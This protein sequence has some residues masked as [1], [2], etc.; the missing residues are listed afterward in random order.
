MG[1]DTRLYWIWLQEAVGRG[2]PLGSEL[3][4]KFGEPWEVYHADRAALKA[5]GVK[6]KADLKALCDKSLRRANAVLTYTLRCR[7]WILTP[8][9]S[10]YPEQLKAIEAPPLVLYGRGEPPRLQDVPTLTIVGTRYCS[11]TGIYAAEKLAA[12]AAAAGITV[13]SGG[14]VGIDAAA[15]RGALR[16]GGVTVLLMPCS[17]DVSYPREN[18]ALRQ[19]VVMSGG[20]LLTEYA[21]TANAYKSH[22]RERNRI[23]SG[24]SLA[25]CVVEAPKRSGALMTANF[26]REQG[27]DVYGVPGDISR[28]SCK[29]SNQ[30]IRSGAAPL[31]SGLDLLEEFSLRWGNHLN[32]EAAQYM[33]ENYKAVRP[34][35]KEEQRAPARREARWENP[36]RDTPSAA[37]ECPEYLSADAKAVFAVLGETALPVDEL[38]AKCGMAVPRVMAV[39]TELELAGCV[40]PAAGQMYARPKD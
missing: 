35:L 6:R 23:L 12:V 36:Q 9:D 24:L 31:C 14:A 7:D 10:Y 19:S 4:K 15:H 18:A 30:L 34:A 37:K 8:A 22:F 16:A 39:L 2:N 38:A 27:R 3:L 32:I 40:R 26:A 25:T 13:I 1:V 29:G 20:A 17:L 33:E 5:A 28:A 11:S 21:P